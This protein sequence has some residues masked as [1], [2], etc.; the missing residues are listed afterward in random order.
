MRDEVFVTVLY[1]Q[2]R[3]TPHN[4][5]KVGKTLDETLKKL[6]E[7]GVVKKTHR[8]KFSGTRGDGYPFE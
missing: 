5:A 1:F 7:S 2:G 8:Q 3:D 6:E 4:R